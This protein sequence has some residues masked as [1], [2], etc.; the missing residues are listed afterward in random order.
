MSECPT[1]HKKFKNLT[2][3][4]KWAHLPKGDVAPIESVKEGVAVE[5]I[6][7]DI[8]DPN[9]LEMVISKMLYEDV[10]VQ[11]CAGNGIKLDEWES[12]DQSDYFK[13]AGKILKYVEGGE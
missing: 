3:H 9:N 7:P 2:L 12:I 6:Q 8:V 13:V 5:G 11:V 10:V 4:K 1:C